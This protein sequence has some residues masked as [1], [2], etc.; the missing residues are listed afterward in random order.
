MTRYARLYQSVRTAHLER[1]HQLAPSTI[2]YAEKRYD[3]D[4]ALAASMNLVDGRGW[5]AAAHLARHVPDVLEVNEPLML[6]SAL[7]TTLAV[8]AMRLSARFQGRPRTRIVSYAIENRD[9]LADPPSARWRTRLKRS[10]RIRAARMLWGRHLDRVVFG[11]SASQELYGETLGP[12]TAK[13]TTIWALPAPLPGCESA[14]EPVVLFVSALSRRKGLDVLLASWATVVQAHP[15]AQLVVVGKGDLADD[16]AAEAEHDPSVTLILDP[17]RAQ[18]HDLLG[19]ARVLALPSRRT[20]TWREQVGLPIVE[21]LAHGCTVVTTTET[22]LADWLAEHGHQVVDPEDV[23]ALS[24]ALVR[25][26]SDPLSVSAVLA[27][28]PERDGRL[29][30]DHWLFEASIGIR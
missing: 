11:T 15:E 1:A 30:A 12:T 20:D 9:P 6:E 5:R 14:R 26:L 17:P 2:I 7:W 21:A 23:S 18:I 19:G 29:A 4:T 3:F 22:G 10:A 25:A 13:S 8:W 27:T 24:T 16:V 28:L